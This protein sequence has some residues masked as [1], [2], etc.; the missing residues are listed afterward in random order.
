[1]MNSGWSNW[2]L[3]SPWMYCAESRKVE[4]CDLSGLRIMPPMPPC[5]G[6][7]GP[8]MFHWL[9]RWKLLLRPLGIMGKC[10]P[11]HFEAEALDVL[12]LLGD[13]AHVVQ[14]VVEG[15]GPR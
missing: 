3:I 11:A 14:H 9:L 5:F 4:P 10:L 6:S 15:W 13:C 8:W 2:D 12:D 1:M 7:A